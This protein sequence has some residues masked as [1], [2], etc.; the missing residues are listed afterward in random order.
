MRIYTKGKIVEGFHVLGTATVPVYLLD[1]PRPA[2]FD[3]GWSFIAHLYKQDMRAI[4]GDRPPAFLFLTHSHFD[5]VGAARHF[6]D[7]WP[8]MQIGGSPRIQE[9]LARPGAVQV[10]R[11]LNRDS[12][13]LAKEYGLDPSGEDSFGPFDIDLGLAG[14][15]VISLGP[16]LSVQAIHAPGHTWDFMSY[17]IPERKILIGSEALGCEDSG[18]D[19]PPEFLVDYDVYRHSL[20]TLAGLDAEVLCPGHRVVLTGRDV[21]E[22]LSRSMET[23]EAF[24]AM[25]EGFLEEEGGHVQRTVER[26]RD[27]E[28]SPKPYP[29]QPEAAYLLNTEARVKKIRERMERKKT[30]AEGAHPGG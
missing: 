2:L 19:I 13:R 6:K 12:A 25:V 17:W 20:E 15:E 21:K 1:G 10:I 23:A 7:T 8:G 18:G 5:H 14:G 24:V 16:D 22:Y 3:A 28:W 26:V 27:R 9:I 29:K 30:K 4:L 11:D